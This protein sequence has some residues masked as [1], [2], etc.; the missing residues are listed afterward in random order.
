MRFMIWCAVLLVGIIGVIVYKKIEPDKKLFR[1][2]VAYVIGIV[3]IA[4]VMFKPW[5]YF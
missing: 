5:R 4:T 3:L 1:L 2:Y